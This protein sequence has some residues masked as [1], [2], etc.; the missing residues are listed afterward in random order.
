MAK[1]KTD[2]ARVERREARKALAEARRAR[3]EARKLA[4]TLSRDARARFEAVTAPALAEISAAR[5]DLGVSPRRA[6]RM[7]RKAAARLE[8]ASIKATASGDAQRR[9]LADRDAKKRAK[10]IKHRRAQAKQ[11]QKMAKFVALHTI[12]ESVT[13]PTDKEQVKADVKRLMRRRREHAG[14]R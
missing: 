11:A 8:K 6:K 3:K 10:T 9:A 14:A 2:T 5:G 12:V 13:T 4:K 1:Q 7:A